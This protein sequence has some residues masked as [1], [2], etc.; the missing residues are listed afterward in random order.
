MRKNFTQILPEI[1][2]F[3]RS[4]IMANE[5]DKIQKMVQITK[6]FLLILDEQKA[7]SYKM[8]LAEEFVEESSKVM[9][10]TYD[11][12]LEVKRMF[13]TLLAYVP[14]IALTPNLIT[15]WMQKSSDPRQ[16]KNMQTLVLYLDNVQKSHLFNM[17]EELRNDPMVKTLLK[18]LQ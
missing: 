9:G 14:T 18:Y 12:D 11:T 8:A 16:I 15:F 5:E 17:D 4:I 1:V 6:N 3:M 7:D 13:N 2:E 10:I